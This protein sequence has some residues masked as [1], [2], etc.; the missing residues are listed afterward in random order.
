[1]EMLPNISVII[2]VY[3]AE[4]HLRQCLDSVI[5][6][7]LKEIEIICID[8]GS[9]DKSISILRSYEEADTRVKI[10]E[11]QNQGAGIARTAG[12]AIAKGKYIAFLDSDDYYTAANSL[13]LLFSNAIQQQAM[14]CGGSIEFLRR[15]KIVS[16]ELQG[17]KYYFSDNGWILYKDFQQDYYYQ[18]FLFSRKLLVENNILFPPYRRYQDPPFFVKAMLTAERFYAISSVVYTYREGGA[19]KVLWT[20][21]KVYDRL[22]GVLDELTITQEAHLDD[23]HYRVTCRVR[24]IFN[25][26]L[27]ETNL[28]EESRTKDA[29]KKIYQAIDQ[30]I[31]Q[32]YHYEDELEYLKD[33]LSDI[34]EEKDKCICIKEATAY[35]SGKEKPKVSVIVPVY[36]VENYLAKCMESIIQQTLQEIE[37]ICVNDES[38]D[39]S[40]QLL[41]SYAAN[42][43]RIAIIDQKNKGL[44]GARNTGFNYA[45][46]KYIYFIDSDD[47]LAL[48]ALEVL[49]NTCEEKNLEAVYFDY[50]RIYDDGS[51][52]SVL[53]RHGYS[54]VYDG[55]SFLKKLRDNHDFTPT[56][57]SQMVLRDFLVQNG[58]EFYQGIIHEDNLFTFY[59]LMNAT[60]VSHVDRKLYYHRLRANSIMTV[61]QSS[62]NV[63]G[64]FISMQEMM[65][66]G[67]QKEW[68]NK[69]M[70]EIWRYFESMQKNAKY[71]LKKLAAEEKAKLNFKNPFSQL[72]FDSFVLETDFSLVKPLDD[73]SKANT[74]SKSNETA[75]KILRAENRALRQEIN[76]I[77]I[78]ISYRVGRFITWLPR[79]IRGGIWCYQEHGWRYTFKRLLIHLHLA[80]DPFK[81]A[82]F[83]N[84][85]QA[86]TNVAQSSTSQES[87][88]KNSDYYSQ[89]APSQYADELKRWYKHVTKRELD[90]DNPK[91]FNEKVQWMK[92][93]DS[94]PLKTKLADKYLVR[95]WVKE[96]IGETYLIPLLGVWKSFDEIDFTKLPEKFVLKANHGCGWNIVVTDKSKFDIDDARKKFNT[97]MKTNFAFKAGLELQY[98]NIQPVI[99]AEEYLENNNDDLYDYKVFC[100]NGK[101]ESIMFLSERKHGLKMAFYDLNWNKLPFVY[102][103]PRNE[104][105]IPKPQ[106]LELLIQLSEKLAEGFAHV[107]VD[108]YVLN[109]GSLKF[110]EMTFSSASGTCAWNPPEQNRIYGDLIKLPPKSP[111]PERK[112]F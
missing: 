67:L 59:V 8:D 88:N 101:A 110:G 106:N 95:D 7:T 94:T 50:T 64:Y 25:S 76:N 52:P 109:D 39:N 77:H 6:Q 44:S 20:P 104:A 34:L 83:D 19:S 55:V 82:T 31:L 58:I 66:F 105:D 5:S 56:A 72:L 12:I 47:Y 43:D 24:S 68:N 9:T 23:L 54:E 36:N 57:W 3:N 65:I 17:I 53:E 42:D 89:L 37:I 22:N 78:S 38:P 85:Y 32:L 71:V 30:N 75:L 84:K 87:N 18:R 61:P 13:E 81:N 16:A 46:G 91:T 26:I 62:K 107:R 49:Y 97:W 80:K 21:E 70:S 28:I 103:Y 73:I 33:Y 69:K 86:T 63:V 79:K 10:I 112:V 29:F 4:K 100:F 35:N 74:S 60:R 93:Y 51:A 11:Q 92:L 90:L 98:M 102:T 45:Q 14:I 27:N 111:I 48:N 41:M 15:G 108:F 1:M 40:L 99:I 96:K 2:P